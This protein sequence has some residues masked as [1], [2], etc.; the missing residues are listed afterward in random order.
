MLSMEILAKYALEIIFG[1]ISAGALAFCKHLW[2]QN[3]EL[4]KMQKA[5][6]SRQYRQMIV[7]EIEPIVEEL[8]RLKEEINQI[9]S[10]GKDKVNELEHASE[11]EHKQMYQDL[12]KTHAETLKALSL[13]IN[14]YKFRLIQLCK[15]H[16]RDGYITAEDFEQVSEMYKLYHGLGGNGQAQEYYEKVLKL[17]MK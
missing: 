9:E 6:Q 14:S 5:D 8:T 1:L 11:E 2:S 10:K 16:L 17:E 15:C 4:V 3:K 13:I 7:D 12:E